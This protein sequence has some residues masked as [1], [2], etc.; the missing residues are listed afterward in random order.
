[1]FEGCSWKTHSLSA[2]LKS[3]VNFEPVLKGAVAA[4]SFFHPFA[5]VFWGILGTNLVSGAHDLWSPSRPKAASSGFSSGVVKVLVSFCRSGDDSAVSKGIEAGSFLT[6]QNNPAWHRQEASDGISSW[7]TSVVFG[8]LRKSSE[9][10]GNRPKEAENF[11][12]Y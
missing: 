9:M 2:L 1:M 12:K 5:T 8:H 11:L 6:F 10:I 7:K 3:P 4:V